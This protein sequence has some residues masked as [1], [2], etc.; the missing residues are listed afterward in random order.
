LGKAVRGWFEKRPPGARAFQMIPHHV[1]Q[2][3]WPLVLGFACCRLLRFGAFWAKEPQ[4]SLFG[5]GFGLSAA[6]SPSPRRF[7]TW[8]VWQLVSRFALHPNH[9][10]VAVTSHVDVALPSGDLP[11]DTCGSW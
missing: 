4:A 3:H 10:G 9:C 11:L 8:H 6:T 7:A 5:C 1:R 2:W